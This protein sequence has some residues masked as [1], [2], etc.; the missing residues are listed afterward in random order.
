LKAPLLSYFGQPKI[1]TKLQDCI[2][3]EK[4]NI[5]LK[6]LVGSSFAIASSA[7]IRESKNPHLFIF[8]DKEEAQYF[9]NEVEALLDNEVFFYPASYRRA[10]QFEETDNA[11]ILLRAEVLNKLNNKRNPIIITYSE[12]LS[13]KV[14]SRKE[15]KRQT[16][17]IKVGDLHELEELENQLTSHHFEKVDFVVEP[18]QFSIRGGILDV[19]SY[20]DEHPFRIEFFDIEVESIRTFDINSQL[21]I[22]AKNKINIVPNIEAKKTDSKHVSFLYYLPNNAIIW[23]KDI[24]YSQG[25]LADYFEKANAHFQELEESGTAHQEPEDLFTS[26]QHFCKQLEDY[27]TIEFGN[28]NYFTAARKLTCN[29]NPHPVFNKQFDLLKSDLIANNE[30]GIKNIILCSSEEQENRF[31]AIFENAEEDLRYQCIHFCLHKGFIDEDNKLA[32]YT[33]HQLF[34][35]HHRFVSKTK[36][37][38]KKAIT[39][40]QLTNL[41]I[42]DFVSHIDHGFGQFAGL[43]K[44][45]N[46]GKHQE[47]IKLTYKDGDILYL[48]I[49]ALH[50]IAKYSG[51]EGFQPKVHQLGSPQWAKTK[52]KTKSKV[53]QIA[54]DLIKLYAKRKTQKGFAFSPDSYLQHELEA[55]FM[56][57]D[58]ADQS[59][60]TASFKEDMEKQMPMDRLVC[61]DVG[62]GKT[63]VAIRAAFKAVADNKQVAILVPTTILALQHFKTFSKRLKDFP[64]NI[65]YINRFRTTKEQ[66]ATIKKLAIGEI[67]IL[68]GTHRIVGKDVV[69]KDLGLMIVDEEQKF[70]VN[71][72]D[73]LKTLKTTVDTLTLS[74][75]PIPRTL[76]FSLL[77]ARDLS[78]INTP[79]PNRQSIETRI[80]G[81]NHEVIRDAISYEMSRNGQVFFVHNRIENIKEVAGLL[82]RLC[83]DAKIKTG[84]GQ[85]EGKQIEKLMIDFM[86]GE[87]DV[88]VSTTI[89]ENGVDIPNANTI[90]INN[91]NNFGL[92][93]L[94]QMRGRVGRSN[95]KAFCYL[96]S[97]PTHQI[98][99]EARRRLDA[100]EQFSTLGSG[101]NIAMRDL[102]TRGAGDLLGADQSGFIND[103][104]FEMY[105]KILD[106]AIE[107][108]KA[109]Q[110]QDL[111]E[112]EKDKFYIKDCALDT[113][114]EILI[115][116]EYVSN[117]EERLNLYK[118][119]N[120]LKTEKEIMAFEMQLKDRFGDLPQAVYQLFDALRLRWLGKEIGFSRIILKSGKMRAYFIN[121]KTSNYFESPQF[122]KVLNHLKN[123]FETT[124]MIE[125]NEKLSL[126]IKGV[127][128]LEEVIHFCKKI[129]LNESPQQDPILRPK[130]QE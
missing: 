51:K 128:K 127:S 44:I 47:V 130:E 41:Q 45:E 71:I 20:A 91:A 48:S 120:T 12:A 6:G 77:G 87:F 19:F 76:Q 39:L 105:K 49:H 35:R 84:H 110:F 121:D 24:A 50:K 60:A 13:E 11:N 21:S 107:E 92:S 118:E 81:L 4:C 78:I 64:C 29:T 5:W 116:D 93:D 38:D 108:L 95:K 97:P 111:F 27:I 124:R 55:S 129:S 26:G 66:N 103:I 18:G 125:K 16:I 62:F 88:L 82:Q 63:E 10:Y 54:F 113:D 52:N 46:N 83:P 74:A 72:K 37:S 56:Y 79:P 122:S 126:A 123:N 112:D 34:E 30:K 119:L 96:I 33:D 115:P 42:G 99:A 58:T 86:E 28:S 40:K 90:I 2:A 104:G 23:T 32:V 117:A 102:D 73:K 65:D 85:M 106:E 75:T 80:I 57:E 67:D 100:L 98:S 114:L 43:H 31:Q 7:A 59:K 17:N 61:G 53:K 1:A 69:F 68:I 8:T 14:V 70:G 109:E 101:F 36:F 3:E 94:H 25:I 89:I 9:V 22:D 15:L